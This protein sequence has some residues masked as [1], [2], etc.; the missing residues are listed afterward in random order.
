L[1]Q[2][3]PRSFTILV[4]TFN[5][6]YILSGFLI[7]AVSFKEQLPIDQEIKIKKAT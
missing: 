5:C 7:F 4:P 6:P 2:I 3:G 1:W